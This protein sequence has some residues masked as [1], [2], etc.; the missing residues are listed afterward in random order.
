MQYRMSVYEIQTCAQG[1][2]NNLLP[3]F[4]LQPVYSAQILNIFLYLKSFNKELLIIILKNIDRR[5]FITSQPSEDVSS[6]PGIFYLW[7][8]TKDVYLESLLL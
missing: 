2:K 5:I 3:I 6:S 8:E 4:P 1:E 7:C